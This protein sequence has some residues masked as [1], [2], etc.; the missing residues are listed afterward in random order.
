M[1]T[2]W[3]VHVHK[4]QHRK[5]KKVSSFSLHKY[6]T[7]IHTPIW[8]YFPCPSLV[9][10]IH[11]HLKQN[12]LQYI[13]RI[14][15]LVSSAHFNCVHH[16]GVWI[17]HMQQSFINT[18]FMS[19]KGT[20]VRVSSVNK[21]CIMNKKLWNKLK[22]TPGELR[23]TSKTKNNPS[24][25]HI[26]KYL[27]PRHIWIGLRGHFFMHNVSFFWEQLNVQECKL[28]YF[29]ICWTIPFNFLVFMDH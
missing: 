25:F 26:S 8:K 1:E 17:R 10:H 18:H 4:V 27:S 19:F 3:F 2:Y 14:S 13:I 5:E 28:A 7:C 12:D 23:G 24:M 16:A 21:W 15:S 9:E 22:F 20:V 6:L 29:L 11:I